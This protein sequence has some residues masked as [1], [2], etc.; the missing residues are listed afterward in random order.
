MLIVARFDP[1]Y[2]EVSLPDIDTLLEM[3]I[4]QEAS[5]DWLNASVR[6]VRFV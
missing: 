2:L 3:T 5:G 4:D 6:L 1:I